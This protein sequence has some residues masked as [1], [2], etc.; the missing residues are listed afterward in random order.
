MVIS[1]WNPR[2]TAQGGDPLL[3]PD[4]RDNE[5]QRVPKAIRWNNPLCR[6]FSFDSN[7]QQGLRVSPRNG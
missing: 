5:I 4:L 2:S 1:W 6:P 3:A 7:R